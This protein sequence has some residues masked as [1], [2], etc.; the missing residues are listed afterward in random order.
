MN[1]GTNATISSNTSA[2]L[3]WMAKPQQFHK[4]SYR[5]V[6]LTHRQVDLALL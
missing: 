4:E 2:L 5:K 1:F 6:K 3:I